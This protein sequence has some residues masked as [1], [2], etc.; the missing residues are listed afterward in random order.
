MKY[1]LIVGKNSYIGSSI[2]EWFSENYNDYTFK[3]IS[4]RNDSW[5]N[6]DFSKYD[7]VIHLAGMVHEREKKENWSQYLMLNSIIPYE[8][9]YK[10]KKSGV[11]HFIFFSTK[12]VYK[13]NIPVI[14]KETV[15]LPTK[16]YGKSKLEGEKSVLSLKDDMFRVSVLRPA[17]VYGEGCKGN[18]P[19]LVKLSKIIHCFPYCKNKRSMIYIWNLCEYTHM[20]LENPIDEDIF[21]PQD[22]KSIGTTDIM[23]ELWRSRGENYHISKFLA[24]CVKIMLNIPK[25]ETLKTAFSSTVYDKSMSDDYNNRYCI[26]TF[27]EA[28]RKIVTSEKVSRRKFV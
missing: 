13:P 23:V 1:V 18:F 22:S 6:E 24:F 27:E 20:L 16:L 2:I 7:A 26:F 11:K 9:A 21:F 5:K 25:F 3:T 17:V 19:K 8:V 28:I 15:P 4:V 10:A 12:G 14:T